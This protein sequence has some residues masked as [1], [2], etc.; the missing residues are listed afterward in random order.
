MFNPS[1]QQTSKHVERL[2]AILADLEA[3]DIDNAVYMLDPRLS[4]YLAV[5]TGR[6]ARVVCE[7]ISSLAAYFGVSRQAAQ[8]QLAR[9]NKKLHGL[10]RSHRISRLPVDELT[11]Q[12]PLPD[13]TITKMLDRARQLAGDATAK[14][15]FHAHVAWRAA[16]GM[17]ACPNPVARIDNAGY[18]EYLVVAGVRHSRASSHF[19]AVCQHPCRQALAWRFAAN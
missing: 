16:N 6:K 19:A 7:N 12:T 4:E 15:L 10:I 13:A 5:I 17:P 8:Q 2:H 11:T 3:E 18:N 14:G 9:L 1:G